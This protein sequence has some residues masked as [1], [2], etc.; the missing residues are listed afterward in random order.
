MRHVT[1]LARLLKD[2]TASVMPMLALAALPVFGAVGAAVDYSRVNATRTAFQ[3]AIDATAL[4]L[5]KEA[6][7]L[8][9]G[10]MSSKASAYFNA[11]FVRPEAYNVS[12][13]PQFSCCSGSFQLAGAR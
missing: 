1:L 13:T 3:A 6:P 4:M 10:Q 12:I 8:T 7:N 9:G 2:P 11:L 5:S